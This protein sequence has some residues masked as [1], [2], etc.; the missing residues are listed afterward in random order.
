MARMRS[1]QLI[2]GILALGSLVGCGATGGDSTAGAANLEFERTGVQVAPET[3]ASEGHAASG[4]K[5]EDRRHKVE[6]EQKKELAALRPSDLATDIVLPD[7]L[8]F[9][10]VH[11]FRG[12]LN[13]EFVARDIPMTELR[14]WFLV[15]M[16]RHGWKLD[17]TRG[18][19]NDKSAVVKFVKGERSCEFAMTNSISLPDGG[20]DYKAG[21]VTVFTSPAPDSQGG[22]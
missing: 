12:K 17:K 3:R 6:S 15:E 19:L 10:K 13:V 21:Y 16:P 4:E 20:R 22:D 9:Q 11:R 14:E 5:E 7:Q 18:W 2:L 8:E 1:I